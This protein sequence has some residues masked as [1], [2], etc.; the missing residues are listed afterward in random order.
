MEDIVA[1]KTAA[2]TKIKFPAIYTAHCPNGPV[3]CC[4]THA[5]G[6]RTLYSVLGCH[7]AITPAAQGSTCIN[8]ITENSEK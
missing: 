6:I 1:K 2:K 7:I 3:D 4:A 5:Q 8:C